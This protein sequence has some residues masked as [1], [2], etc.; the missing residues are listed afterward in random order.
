[1]M[2]SHSGALWAARALSQSSRILSS[3]RR[4]ITLIPESFY[5]RIGG[6]RDTAHTVF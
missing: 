5:P 6:M 1:M 3:S 4:L 2:F